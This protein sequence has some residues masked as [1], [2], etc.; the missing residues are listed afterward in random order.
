M[1]KIVEQIE[2]LTG[3]DSQHFNR[4][5][6]KYWEGYLKT[7]LIIL[8]NEVLRLED[9]GT[10]L[11]GRFLIFQMRQS[12]YGREDTELTPKLLA[13]R[14]GILNLALD[15]LGRLKARGHPIQ[16]QSGVEMAETF[17]EASSTV[18]G[19][20]AERCVTGTAH[21]MLLQTAYD[22]WKGYCEEHGVRFSWD[23]ATFSRKL[24]AAVSTITSGRPRQDNSRKRP[25][26]LYGIRLLKR[27]D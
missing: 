7:R 27:G 22:A 17:N 20:V 21:E 12:F 13:E 4:K 9:E 15:A 23:D 6:L 3:E 16:C 1:G 10:A 2:K 25:T 14:A 19:F 26:M 8:A 11:A 18:S 24:R 5:Y